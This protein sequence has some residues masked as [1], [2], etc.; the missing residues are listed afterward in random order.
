MRNQQFLRSFVWLAVFATAALALPACGGGSSGGSPGSD[1][2][3]D[4]YVKSFLI[5]DQFGNQL[6]G[7]QSTNV[8]RNARLLIEFNVGVEFSSVSDRTLRVGIPVTLPDGS[9]L[10]QEAL[11]RI[12]QVP[13]RPEQVIFNPTSTTV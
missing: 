7:Q 9:S 6:G 5:V 3:E 13:G 10:L 8:Y 1:R 2:N 11:G 4:L 12:E